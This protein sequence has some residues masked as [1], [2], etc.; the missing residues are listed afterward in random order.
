MAAN[1]ILGPDFSEIDKY[2]EENTEY[3]Y[4][5]SVWPSETWGFSRSVFDLFQF[6]N[7]RVEMTMTAQGFEE[8]RSGLSRSGFT[9]RE[10]E[11]VPYVEPEPL[12]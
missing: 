7:S 6:L 4:S 9:L 1:S 8:F 3:T 10:V 5:F 12:P 2:M 11:R